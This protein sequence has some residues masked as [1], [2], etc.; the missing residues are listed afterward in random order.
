[1]VATRRDEPFE[2]R[3]PES[4]D[5]LGPEGS[6]WDDDEIDWCQQ[7]ITGSFASRGPSS[8]DISECRLSRVT[9]AGAD[10][11][12]CLVTDVVLEDCD[13]SGASFPQARW[14]RVELRRCRLTG[15][16]LAGARLDDVRF[17]DCKLDEAALDGS[18]GER[19]WF[20]GCTMRSTTLTGVTIEHLRITACDLT[21]ADLSGA[22][23]AGAR[24]H[25]STLDR[26]AGV[27]SLRAVV[28][29]PDQVVP[30]GLQLLAA[31]EIEVQGGDS[32]E[33]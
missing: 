23:V 27:G 31:L 8:L 21:G 15:T 3:L 29:D 9:L 1:M 24:L 13:L 25:G 5:R 18:H 30:L 2:P 16:S 17:V 33:R 6:G 10:V 32:D 19:L 14:S 28:V 12:R 26:L 7:D 11:D 22:R 4:L 20:D